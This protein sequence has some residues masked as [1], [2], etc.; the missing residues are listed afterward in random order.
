[1]VS[2][3]TLERLPM[4]MG[5]FRLNLRCLDGTPEQRA[6]LLSGIDVA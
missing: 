4:Q 3:E 1:M 2:A 6:A 5:Y